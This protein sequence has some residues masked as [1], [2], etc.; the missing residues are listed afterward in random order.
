MST[1]KAI[2]CQHADPQ[3]T[4]VPSSWGC[5]DCLR[6][7]ASWVHLRLCMTCG[8]VGCCDQSPN[9]HATAHAHEHPDHP[10]IRS[11]EPHEDWWYC[12]ADDLMFDIPGAP[13]APSHP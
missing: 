3:R 10:V 2:T 8:H 4:V 9:R 6:M 5:E 7:G 1:T 12:Y 13:P 11:F